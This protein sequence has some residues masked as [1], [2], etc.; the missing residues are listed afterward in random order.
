VLLETVGE[1]GVELDEITVD[2][3]YLGGESND[4]CGAD[5]FGGQGG[6][7][8]VGG[9]DSRRGDGGAVSTAAFT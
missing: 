1:L 6:E 9:V 3:G 5:R 4:H 8:L 7:L 2:L